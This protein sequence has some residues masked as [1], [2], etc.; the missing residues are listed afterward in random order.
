MVLSRWLHRYL[1]VTVGATYGLI[2]FGA[3][4]TSNRAGLS[5]PDWPTT[6]SYSMFTFPVERWVGGVFYE[7]VHRLIA[8]GVGLL[9]MVAAVWIHAAD[10]R[11]TLRMMGLGAVVAVMAQGVLGGMTVL[12]ALPATLSIAHAALAQAFLCLL[13]GLAMMTSP[14]WQSLPATSDRRGM[15]PWIALLTTIVIF[16]QLLLGATLRHAERALVPHIVGAVIT[17][18]CVSALTMMAV[19][20]ERPRLIFWHALWLDGLI[21]IQLLV[22]VMALLVRVPKDA[23]AVLNPVQIWVPSLHVILGALVLGTSMVL[24]LAAFRSH[25]LT[26]QTAQA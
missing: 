23:P 18:M 5:V 11:W 7:H 14:A 24:T 16:T 2:A 17:L 15:L 12:K 26:G 1:W 19:G 3:L 8:S 9:A 4:V 6:Y 10:R 22:G 25:R 20:A 13:I 21:V